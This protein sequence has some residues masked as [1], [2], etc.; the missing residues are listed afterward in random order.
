MLDDWYANVSNFD[1]PIL[2]RHVDDALNNK[3]INWLFHLL[4]LFVD[5]NAKNANDECRNHEK[6]Q[7]FFQHCYLN[8]CVKLRIIKNDF[9]INVIYLIWKTLIVLQT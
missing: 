9:I 1:E 6:Y 5:G 7:Q 2:T 4:L 3:G 8:V